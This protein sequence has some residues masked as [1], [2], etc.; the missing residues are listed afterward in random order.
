VQKVK[1]QV[2]GRRDVCGMVGHTLVFCALGLLIKSLYFDPIN[3][4]SYEDRLAGNVWRYETLGISVLRTYQPIRTLPGSNALGKPL[5]P[6]CFIPR[7]SVSLVI[8]VFLLI[9]QISLT[10]IILHVRLKKIDSFAI[11]KQN[12]SNSQI[13]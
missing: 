1:S 5:K 8:I 6:Q 10:R 4:V 2:Y 7:V 13:N 11:N 3:K 12:K 9:V